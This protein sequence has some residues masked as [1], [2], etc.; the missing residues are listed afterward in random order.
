MD[1][2]NTDPAVPRTLHLIVRHGGTS[3]P[4]LSETRRRRAI[5]ALAGNHARDAADLAF[6]LD[7]LGLHARDGRPAA[8]TK[9][10]DRK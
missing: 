4:D 3:E 5:R 8:P 1:E 2:N 7:V 9:G 6:L 10:A